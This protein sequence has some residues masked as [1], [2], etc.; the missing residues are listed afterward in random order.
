MLDE[1]QLCV[2]YVV[3]YCQYSRFI[4]TICRTLSLDTLLL[5]YQDARLTM[6]KP[7]NINT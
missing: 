7:L 6:P 5:Y 1:I 2:P 4:Y 3:L